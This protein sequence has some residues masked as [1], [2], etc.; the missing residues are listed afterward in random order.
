MQQAKVTDMTAVMKMIA[1]FASTEGQLDKEL[2]IIDGNDEHKKRQ[3][4]NNNGGVEREKKEK[5]NDNCRSCEDDERCV[6]L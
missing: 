3:R 4:S 5:R 6:L 1:L 2:L